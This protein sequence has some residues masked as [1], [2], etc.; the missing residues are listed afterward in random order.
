MVLLLFQ[1]LKKK[2]QSNKNIQIFFTDD[3]EQKKPYNYSIGLSNNC[4]PLNS[5]PNSLVVSKIELVVSENCPTGLNTLY[6]QLLLL[7]EFRENYLKRAGRTIFPNFSQKGTLFNS[8]S[9]SLPFAEELVQ[10]VLG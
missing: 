9:G 6:K 1:L 3:E 5:V 2:M 10:E 7:D 8:P 4:D